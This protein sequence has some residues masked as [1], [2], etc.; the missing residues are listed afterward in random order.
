MSSL[1]SPYLC[2]KNLLSASYDVKNL[3]CFT[4][5]VTSWV[6]GFWK[7]TSLHVDKWNGQVGHRIA[8]GN[9]F[10]TFG[11]ILFLFTLLGFLK[12]PSLFPVKCCSYIT[13]H[14]HN[15][16]LMFFAL[17]HVFSCSVN[18]SDRG[19]R[20]NCCLIGYLIM[21]YQQQRVFVIKWNER[22]NRCNEP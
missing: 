13:A 14:V 16:Q 22:K 10:L 7:P 3:C 15:Y 21:L 4:W 12:S 6:T 19:S 2:L 8:V 5:T 1:T 20:F 17:E 18:N 11:N 9:W